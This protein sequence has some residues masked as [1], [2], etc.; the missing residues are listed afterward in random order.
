MSLNILFISESL[1]KDR[2][3][4]SSAIDGKQL[5]PIIK[6]A[7]DK[8]ILPCLGSGLYNRLQSGINNA[9]LTNDEKTLLNDYVTDTLLWFTIG[10]SVQM[11]GYQFFSKGV[12]Q[13]TS[14]DS[15]APGKGTLELIE[16]K[17]MSNGEFYKQR[18]IA[19]LQ[20]NYTLY[21]QY[22][23]PG[24]GLDVIFPQN[25]AYTSPIYLG[26]GAGARLQRV[27][28]GGGANSA[29]NYI[30]YVVPSDGTTFTI[31][32]LDGKTILSVTRSG[33]AKVITSQT[34]TDSNYIQVN[35]NVFTAPTGNDFITGETFIILYR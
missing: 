28:S 17:Y 3:G 19:Y 31:A 24:T 30:N 15:N 29:T 14:E 22:L 13:K 11:L 10:E 21:E 26:R 20:E 23:N 2:T 6:L 5:K 1:I 12:F 25:K 33:M 8:Y 18:L 4:I 35:N 34:T 16:R 27:L 32:A 9:N 7:Q